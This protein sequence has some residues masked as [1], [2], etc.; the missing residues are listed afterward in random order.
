MKLHMINNVLQHEITDDHVPKHYSGK[1]C[2]QNISCFSNCKYKQM[3]LGAE[4]Y[5]SSEK[6][7]LETLLKSSDVFLRVNF[8][9][10]SRAL[11]LSNVS[12]AV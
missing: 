4:V 8:L 1:T 5:Q 11:K 2:P 3:R 10:M 6:L 7:L 9:Q 12:R